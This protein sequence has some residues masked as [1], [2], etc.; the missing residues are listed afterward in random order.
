[1][2]CCN[3]HDHRVFCHRGWPWVFWL[4]CV[5]VPC[6][7]ILAGHWISFDKKIK[8]NFLSILFLLM[9]RCWSL[10]GNV[11]TNINQRTGTSWI[12]ISLEETYHL[13]YIID[14]GYS[15]I[16][17]SFVLC[18]TKLFCNLHCFY[19]QSRIVVFIWR[20]KWV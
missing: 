14:F 10:N 6:V 8:K 19:T 12:E 1:M 15:L 9:K 2:D 7:Y 4:S 18:A 11:R 17:F 13:W 3:R 16:S 5:V 20:N